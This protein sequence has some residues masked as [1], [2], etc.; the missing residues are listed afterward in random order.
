MGAKSIKTAENM[1]DG[2]YLKFRSKDNEMILGWMEYFPDRTKSSW[3][4]DY[5][6]QGK[7]DA[8]VSP[9]NSYG[10]MDG[11]IDQVYLNHFG[12]GLQANLQKQIKEKHNGKLEVGKAIIIPTKDLK[13]PKMIAAPTME[14]PGDISDTDNVY[15]AFKAVLEE[16]LKYNHNNK[17][18]IQEI[19]IPG[20]GTGVGR[21]K[22]FKAAEQM[23][24]AYDTVK[25]N[26][27]Q[28][29]IEYLL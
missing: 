7:A 6:I 28:K 2:L 26:L 20:M 11:G 5:I 19:I 16:T 21:M 18:Q 29:G 3:G 13:I 24:Q 4:Y 8:I 10:Y 1:L 23:K 9:A 12:L 27:N 14:T 15:K 17:K 25:Q 22:P